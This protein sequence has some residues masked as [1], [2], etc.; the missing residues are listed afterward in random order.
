MVFDSAN[1]SLL[2]TLSYIWRNPI[3]FFFFFEIPKNHPNIKKF[4]L[5]SDIY[6]KCYMLYM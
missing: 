5:D 1:T 2:Y 3:L 6:C 4:P